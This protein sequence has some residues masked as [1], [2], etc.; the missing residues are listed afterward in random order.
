[1]VGLPLAELI[2]PDVSIPLIVAVLPLALAVSLGGGLVPALAAGRSTVALGMRNP[3]VIRTSHLPP[4][5]WRLGVD[6][7]LRWRRIE[8][9]VP[10]AVV[11]VSGTL[12]G[13]MVAI[14]ASFRGQ[15]DATVL[16]VYL[17]GRVEPFHLAVAALTL[18]VGAVAAGQAVALHY[19]ERQ[20]ELAMLRAIGW[21]RGDVVAYVAG[22]ALALAA[23]GAVAAAGLVAV[24]MLV[25]DS[26]LSALLIAVTA[27]AIAPAVAITIATAGTLG[28]AFRISPAA[29][30][31]G[32]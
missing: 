25:L 16:G 18:V 14:E 9:V 24:V 17:A 7:A 1:V 12:L 2:S 11:A 20:P 28:H 13:A 19:L 4:H 29:L 32:E 22:G 23:L 5:P 27:A 30:L 3:G 10:V 6:Q 21:R 26:G 31:R 15:L 8:S